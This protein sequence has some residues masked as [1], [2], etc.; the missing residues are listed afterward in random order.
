LSAQVAVI[1]HE[2]YNGRG[3]SRI[4]NSWQRY[5][6]ALLRMRE[7]GLLASDYDE[8]APPAFQPGPVP[9]YRP[10]E[11]ALE[12]LLTA[13]SLEHVRHVLAMD[14]KG[15]GLFDRVDTPAWRGVYRRAAMAVGGTL[16]AAD[17]IGRGEAKHVF[18][19]AGGLHHAK[20]DKAAGF[21][22]FNDIVVAARH[23]QSRY[24]LKRIAVL[25]IDGHH[26]DGTQ[27]LLYHEPLL[28]VSLHMYDGRFYPGTGSLYE[29]GDGAG[30]G[31][32]LNLP[33]PRHTTDTEYLAAFDL[34]LKAVEKYRP[35]AIILQFGVD[36]HFSDRMV[37]LKLSTRVYEYIAA[38]THSLA[39]RVC[40]GRLVVVGGGGYVP[41]TVARC[42]AILVSQLSNRHSELGERYEA[43][44]DPPASLPLPNQEAV[45][46][47]QEMLREAGQL[48]E[49]SDWR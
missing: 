11:A 15:E 5:R 12:D 44:H 33:L 22:I 47:A 14:E 36:G 17:L 20:Y 41:E 32:S 4:E 39:H 28:T 38:Q 45:I 6:G 26:G 27:S 34:S 46:K 42:W 9:V 7:L 43:L 16:L 10:Q 24:G 48:I 19:P 23:W 37:G 29:R 40:E 3:F 30:A 2:L 8:T 21:C 18:H 13:H 1:Y 25:D 49:E 35:E 31:Y